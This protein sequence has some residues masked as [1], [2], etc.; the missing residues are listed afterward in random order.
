M[1]VYFIYILFHL[2]IST[3]YVCNYINNAF[4]IMIPLPIMYVTYSYTL[5]GSIILLLIMCV[6]IEQGS[7]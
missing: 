4:W 6:N 1:Y 2:R 5:M 3:Y 7:S